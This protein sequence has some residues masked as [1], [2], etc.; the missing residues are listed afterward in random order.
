MVLQQCEE[1]RKALPEL[2][3]AFAN[4]FVANPSAAVAVFDIIPVTADDCADIN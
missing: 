2:D 3:L 1:N 4:S